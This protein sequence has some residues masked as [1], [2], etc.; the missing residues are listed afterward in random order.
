MIKEL[1]NKYC[2]EEGYSSF[3]K[4]NE[5]GYVIWLENYIRELEVKS[6]LFGVVRQS[7]QL[8]DGGVLMSFDEWKSI[9]YKNTDKTYL[10]GGKECFEYELNS[11]YNKLLDKSI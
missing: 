10:I 7:E 8:N 11:I 1:R 4:Y 2:K 6:L 5:N 3:N 9:L